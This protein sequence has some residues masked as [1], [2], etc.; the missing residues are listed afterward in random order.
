MN[1]VRS[2]LV[3]GA[4]IYAFLEDFPPLLGAGAAGAAG[5]GVELAAGLDVELGVDEELELLP[6]SFFAADL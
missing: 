5:A 4:R 3:H 1:S 2:T 6:V